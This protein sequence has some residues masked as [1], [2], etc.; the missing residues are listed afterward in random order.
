MNAALATERPP[1]RLKLTPSSGLI[2]VDIGS[3][4]ARLAQVRRHRGR[5]VISA[6]R[7]LPQAGD[8]P[9]DQQSLVSGAFAASF[10]GLSFRDAGFRGRRCAALLTGAIAEPRTLQL[11]SASSAET[12]QM[13][14][15]ELE[16]AP[17]DG[18]ASE[19]LE[20]DLW[21]SSDSAS[22]DGTTR[23]SVMSAPQSAA[24]TVALDLQQH[25]LNCEVLDGLPFAL[26]RAVHFVDPASSNGTFATL[27]WGCH[28][29]LLTVVQ[30]GVPAFHRV[31]RDCGLDHAIT[32]VRDEFSV[33]R[34]EASRLLAAVGVCRPEADSSSGQPAASIRRAIDRC[35][36]PVVERLFEQVRRSLAFLRQQNRRLVPDSLWLFGGG[37]ALNGIDAAFTSRFEL[38]CRSWQ[39]A[40]RQI[41]RDLPVSGSLAP[42]GAA[43]GLSLLVEEI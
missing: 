35:T 8:Q 7:A 40:P 3:R 43:V 34:F 16:D 23:V 5:W 26:A 4:F 33:S 1:L 37:A 6:L 21:T 17:R 13:A 36:Q 31:F 29:P 20:F 30:N 12:E 15:L 2:G 41:A 19:S 22:A 9:L 25:G 24:A 14:K 10:D 38:P 28:T 39:P 27:D 42:F 11:P 32:A 18:V